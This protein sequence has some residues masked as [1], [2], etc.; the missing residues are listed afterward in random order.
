MTLNINHNLEA[1]NI[2]SELMSKGDQIFF[3]CKF[4]FIFLKDFI[5]TLLMHWELLHAQSY[6]SEYV[7][8]GFYKKLQTLKVQLRTAIETKN[9]HPVTG[10]NSKINISV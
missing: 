9:K 10:N 6:G 7:A 8:A 1:T 3:L 2:H 4:E 5:K